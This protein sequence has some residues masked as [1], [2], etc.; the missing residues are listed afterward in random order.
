M[1]TPESN[2]SAGA[3]IAPD[4]PKR[5]FRVAKKSEKVK[6]TR[7]EYQKM[8]LADPMLKSPPASIIDRVNFRRI[9]IPSKVID[10]RE[11]AQ[12]Q[13]LANII[14]NQPLDRVEIFKANS[15]GYPA[16]IEL[17]SPMI[18]FVGEFKELDIGEN[19]YRA[20]LLLKLEEKTAAGVE[21]F[22]AAME[23]AG[24]D[25]Y[26]GGL[27]D[28]EF[29][30]VTLFP[31]RVFENENGETGLFN[32]KAA[33]TKWNVSHGLPFCVQAL[34]KEGTPFYKDGKIMTLEG[35]KNMEGLKIRAR[36]SLAS[37][38]AVDKENDGYKCGFTFNLK[39]LLD[40]EKI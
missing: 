27:T 34:F 37:Y 9:L 2:P 7:E 18:D 25:V 1:N 12:A 26:Q 5:K 14:V 38:F 21:A 17:N 31:A 23:T 8:Y 6:E 13:D 4:A 10:M 35:L 19:N 20:K 29:G 30:N 40:G 33:T 3:P 36:C 24:V 39:A 28:E 16:V 15:K 22:N 11:I 32:L